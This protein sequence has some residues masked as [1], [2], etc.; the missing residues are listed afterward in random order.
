VKHQVLVSPDRCTLWVNSG[1][2]SACLARFSSKG[3]D[4]H[5]DMDKQVSGK[6]HC[7]FC[8]V[9]PDPWNPIPLRS[10]WELFKT[11]LAELHGVKI[12][13]RVRLRV[14]EAA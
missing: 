4:I 14:R 1:V 8:N 9:G 13:S 2:T 3:I 12:S 6:Q 10:E 11:K 5:V 7:L